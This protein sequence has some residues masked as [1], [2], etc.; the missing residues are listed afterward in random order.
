M[1]LR[2]QPLRKNNPCSWHR[3][4]SLRPLQGSS[5]EA[6]QVVDIQGSRESSTE[7][8]AVHGLGR[9]QG[10]VKVLSTHTGHCVSS[11]RTAVI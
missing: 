9:L 5:A 2:T 10:H 1:F 3:H 11:S 7:G 8:E 4:H 6:K